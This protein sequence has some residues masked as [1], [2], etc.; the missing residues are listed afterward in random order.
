MDPTYLSSLTVRQLRVFAM[1]A[2]HMSFTRAAQALGCQQPTV[3]TMVA[4]LENMT[5][6][7]LF[8]SEGKRLLFTPEGRA[9]FAHAQEVI[10][11][12]D[13]LR[14]VVTRLRGDYEAGAPSLCVA[15]DTTVGAYV[16][17]HV[18]GAFH[19][20]YPHI[21][22]NL[23]VANR[24]TVRAQLDERRADLVVA[25]RPPAVEGLRFQTF[26][27]NPLVVVAAPQHRLAGRTHISLAEIAEE[28]FLLREEGSGV[29]AALEELFEVSGMPLKIGMTLGH[30]ESIKQAT[31]ANLGV[32]ALSALAVQRELE[33]GSLTLLPVEGFPIERHWFIAY[34]DGRPLSLSAQAFLDFAQD[35][36]AA[37]LLRL[38]AVVERYMRALPSAVAAGGE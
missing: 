10:A 31:Q 21:P 17:P 37:A 13:E 27:S 35:A 4:R 12:A 9:L 5:H 14:M 15:A 18:L 20:R 24:S 22:F 3:S 2:Q 8:E 32:S 38:R 11:A 7:T 26:L 1:V 34:L 25:E 23:I 36:D 19:R 16:M 28:A 30:I 6:L 29:R 33:Q